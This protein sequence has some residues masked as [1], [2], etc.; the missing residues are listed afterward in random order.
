M[1]K[2]LENYIIEVESKLNGKI[3]KNDL[4]NHLNKI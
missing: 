3:T 1:R 4:E 2:Y